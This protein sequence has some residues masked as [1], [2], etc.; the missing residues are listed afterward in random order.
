MK[1]PHIQIAEHETA[2]AFPLAACHDV[3][4]VVAQHFLRT[5]AT[6]AFERFLLVSLAISRAGGH[7]SPSHAPVAG[8]ASLIERTGDWLIARFPIR[9]SVSFGSTSLAG[10]YLPF[11]HDRGTSRQSL[12]RYLASTGSARCQRQ[13]FE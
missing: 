6:L 11:R 1:T 8:Y 5:I 12:R 10:G 4:W 3:L 9:L 7:Q 13:P 2:S